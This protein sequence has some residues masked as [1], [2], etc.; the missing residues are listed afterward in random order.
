MTALLERSLTRLERLA[1]LAEALDFARVE[2]DEE[3]RHA[4][5]LGATVEQLAEITGKS[6]AR[7]Y[8]IR[9]GRR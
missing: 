8:Q 7:V 9:D 2:R 1:G 4:L 6:V 3:I 5:G